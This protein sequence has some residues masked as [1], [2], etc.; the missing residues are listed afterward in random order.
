[1]TLNGGRGKKNTELAVERD[2]AREIYREARLVD[3]IE[4]RKRGMW[5]RGLVL[6]DLLEQNYRDES[7]LSNAERKSIHNW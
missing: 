1:M 6:E 5:A 3:R 7:R 2:H 4:K